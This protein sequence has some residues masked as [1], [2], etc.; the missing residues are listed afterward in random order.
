M[1]SFFLSKRFMSKLSDF[2]HDQVRP[3]FIMANDIDKR[4][5]AASIRKNIDFKGPNVVILACAIIVASV[6]LNV[7]SIPVIIGAMLI[8]P[9]MGPILGMGLALGTYDVALMNE[10]LK[11]FGIMVGISIVAASLFFLASPLDLNNPTELLAR[12][13]PTVYDVLVALFGG[14]AGMLE[15]AR[16]EKGTV[17]AGVAIA[18]ALMPPLCTI[19]YGVSTLNPTYIFGAVYLFLINTVFIMLATFLTVKYLEFPSNEIDDDLL[20]RR[21]P[22]VMT[23][24]LVIILIPSFFSAVMIVRENN[25]SR[26]A[27]RFVQENRVIGTSYIFDHTVSATR[28]GVQTL[29]IYL[30][31]EALHPEAREKMLESAAAHGIRNEQLVLHEDAALVITDPADIVK[32]IH[33][34]YDGQIRDLSRLLDELQAEVD[35]ICAA[36][37]T[38]AVDKRPI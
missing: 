9:V 11:N 23:V 15:Q 4:A 27:Q 10:S 29:E 8:S 3:L 38:T 36:A 28:R 1:Q 22:R 26:N 20:R 18:T 35:R 7:N 6:G 17:L 24:V 2:M 32:D 5:A 21:N 33:D 12:T 14:A 30:A 37:D 25:F 19:G 13:R 34:Y 16:K 31:G